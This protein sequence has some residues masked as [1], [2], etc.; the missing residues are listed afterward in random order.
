MMALSNSVWEMTGL[1]K[2]GVGELLG[3]GGMIRMRTERDCA[4]FRLVCR[5]A[6]HVIE[7]ET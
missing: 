6:K 2:G 4:Q 7:I 5:V 1:F 3:L